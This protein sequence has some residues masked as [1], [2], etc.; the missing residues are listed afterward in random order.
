M[1]W[2]ST[3]METPSVDGFLCFLKRIH[4]HFRQI[5]CYFL[6]QGGLGVSTA[7]TISFTQYFGFH[8]LLLR[9]RRS[10]IFLLR[11]WYQM[12]SASSYPP[13]RPR[14]ASDH[15][16]LVNHPALFPTEHDT[17]AKSFYTNQH[18]K[19]THHIFDPRPKKLR[20]VDKKCQAQ[21]QRS[22]IGTK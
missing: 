11:S 21:H 8:G 6:M 16:C 3:G 22:N 19:S 14:P 4:T 13:V 2:T 10:L 7:I 9:Y 15:F 1:R 18:G 20:Y 17:T 12:F 5:I